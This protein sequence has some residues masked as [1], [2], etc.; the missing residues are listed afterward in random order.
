[1][2][3]PAARM[4]VSP[5]AITANAESRVAASADASEQPLPTIPE[6]TT[7]ELPVAPDL[8][9]RSANPLQGARRGLRADSPDDWMTTSNAWTAARTASMARARSR[10]SAKAF[11]SLRPPEVQAASRSLTAAPAQA[12]EADAP[13]TEAAEMPLAAPPAHSSPQAGRSPGLAPVVSSPAQLRSMPQGAQLTQ[14]RQAGRLAESPDDWM[15]TAKL[16]ASTRAARRQRGRQRALKV[17]SPDDWMMKSS[18]FDTVVRSAR[19]SSG[20]PTL[21][22]AAV[23]PKSGQLQ[24]AQAADHPS[25]WMMVS[26]PFDTSVESAQAPGGLVTQLRSLGEEAVEKVEAHSFPDTEL[27]SMDGAAVETVNL[28]DMLWVDA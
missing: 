19:S 10:P 9:P 6:D 13:P 22:G 20:G 26:S 23:G 27:R 18:P 4:G 3:P 1:L 16:L 8:A 25:D 7:L 17:D 5:A 11:D 24:K 12:L 28:A 15:T 14:G 21:S 2:V